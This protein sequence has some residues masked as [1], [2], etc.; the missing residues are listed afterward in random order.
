MLLMD[1]LLLQ[2]AIYEP[3]PPPDSE[4]PAPPLPRI[5]MKYRQ[6]IYY[7]SPATLLNQGDSKKQTHQ[8][9]VNWY[10]IDSEY[11]PFHSLKIFYTILCPGLVFSTQWRSNGEGGIKPGRR[12]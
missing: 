8:K 10:K 11:F 6:K 5:R 1:E 7:Y 9:F 4:F 12:P 2:I 3:P